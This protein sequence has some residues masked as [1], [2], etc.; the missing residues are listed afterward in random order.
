MYTDHGT[1][2]TRRPA[3]LA[4]VPEH[5]PAHVHRSCFCGWEIVRPPGLEAEMEAVAHL[6]EEHAT[7]H[8]RAAV[9]AEFAAWEQVFAELGKKLPA[10]LCAGE[11]HQALGRAR[12]SGALEGVAA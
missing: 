4:P 6:L 11:V 3:H 12:A 10:H 9:E 2:R 8:E 7:V 5:Q 1:A